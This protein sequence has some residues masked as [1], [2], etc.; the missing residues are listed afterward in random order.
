MLRGFATINYWADDLDAARGGHAELRGVEPYF[1]RPGPGGQPA[2]AELRIGGHQDGL[3]L[4]DR[5]RAPSRAATET[6]GRSC[7]VTTAA[8]RRCSRSCCRGS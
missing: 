3:G 4:A 5:R 6:A 2:R 1:E 7:T 8:S